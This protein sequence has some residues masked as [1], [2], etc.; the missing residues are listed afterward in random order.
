MRL[1]YDNLCNKI[2]HI[3]LY[4]YNLFPQDLEKEELPPHM[5]QVSEAD[6]K[7]VTATFVKL[8]ILELNMEMFVC[9]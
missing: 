2:C 5:T 9:C 3:N 6:I 1:D 8:L 4:S 7:K